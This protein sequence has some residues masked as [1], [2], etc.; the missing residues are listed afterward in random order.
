MRYLVIA[1]HA[2]DEVYGMG[3]TIL[4]LIACGHHVRVV[5]VCVG[6]VRFEHAGHV[7][8]GVRVREAMAVAAFLGVELRFLSFSQESFLDTVP[9]RSIVHEIET[10]HDEFGADGWYVTGPSCHQDHRVVFEAA[11]TAARISRSTAPGTVLL[12]ELP[13]YQM[14]PEIWRFRP[15]LWENVHGYIDRKIEACLLYQSQVRAAGPLA[16][17]RLRE[18]AMM[19]GSEC[20]V[21]AAERFEIVRI[22]R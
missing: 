8:A 17:S 6:D 15:H 11:M 10:Q 1:P 4:K 5:I 21:A 14:N 13:M 19:C 18:W 12:Y 16:P 9:I 3:G 20:G 2:D 22:V 7:A